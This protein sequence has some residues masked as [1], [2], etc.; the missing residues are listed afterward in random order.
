MAATHL[1]SW[2]LANF[3]DGIETPDAEDFRR[4]VQLAMVRVAKAVAGEIQGTFRGKHWLKRGV[5]AANILNTQIVDGQALVGSEI[6]L[7]PFANAV[8]DNVSI[9]ATSTDADIEFTI[10][11]VFDDLAGV[12]GSD[13]V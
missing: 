12:V 1:D 6:W 11:S 2:K 4:R 5:L 8:A 9:V 13:L 7:D 10:A 3:V